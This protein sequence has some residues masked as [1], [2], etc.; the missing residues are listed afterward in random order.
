MVGKGLCKEE[1]NEVIFISMED[2]VPTN[3]VFPCVLS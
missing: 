2:K 1:E 3:V